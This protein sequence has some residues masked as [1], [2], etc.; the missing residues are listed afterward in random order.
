MKTT[1][2]HLSKGGVGKTTI[3]IL[4]AWY[5]RRIGKRVLFVDFD[6]QCNSSKVLTNVDAADHP[7]YAVRPIGTILDFAGPSYSTK[8]AALEPG[9]FDILVAVEDVKFGPTEGSAI[10]ASVRTLIASDAYDVAIFDTSPVL[11]EQV[12]ALLQT[13]DNLLMPMRPDDFSFDQIGVVLELKSFADQN[14]AKPL[15]VAGI[16]INGMMNKPTMQNTHQLVIRGYPEHA[17]ETVI[18]ASEPIRIAMEKSRPVFTQSTSW[19]RQKRNE[20]IAAFEQVNRKS[21]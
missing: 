10:M 16:L 6:M 3:S 14:R 4:Y 8:L 5:L 9:P 11:D 15:N 18:D 21:A 12:A 19:A 2:V 17:I 20:L 1:M 7:T 13:V